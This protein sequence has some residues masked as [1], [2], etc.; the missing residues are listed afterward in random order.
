[1]RVSNS[2]SLKIDTKFSVN[3][4]PERVNKQNILKKYARQH[5]TVTEKS[6]FLFIYYHTNDDVGVVSP[7]VIKVRFDC[8]EEHTSNHDDD[9]ERNHSHYLR[10][11]NL[12]RFF[13]GIDHIK[14]MNFRCKNL[15]LPSSNRLLI[16][17]SVVFGFSLLLKQLFLRKSRLFLIAELVSVAG[18]Q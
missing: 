2:R 16:I 3:P 4:G 8:E 6:C 14:N 7:L 10:N 11:G 13:V 17:P 1:M 9:Q 15:A 18:K 5:T 12:F